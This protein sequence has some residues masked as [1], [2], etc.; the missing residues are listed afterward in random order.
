MEKFMKEIRKSNKLDN[1][2]YDIRGP[3]VEEA[4]RLEREGH[5]IIKLNTGNPSAFGL[6]APDEIIQDVI[7]NLRAAEAYGDSKGLF[8]ARKAI[9]QDCQLKGIRD[10]AIEDIIVGNGVSELIVMIMQGL[11]NNGDEV[12]VPM[13]DYP[14]WTGAANLAGGKAVHYLC[15]ESSNWYPDLADIESKITPNTRAIVMINPNNPTGAVYPKEIVEKMVDIAVKNQLVFLADEIYD[16]VMYDGLKHTPAASLSDD[17]L[18]IT[19]NGLS[20][21]HRLCGFRVGWM[22]ISGKKDDAKDFI[23]GLSILS[24]MRLCSN[25][26]AQ[27][28]IQTAIG[29][30][31]SIFDLT[32]PGGRLCEQRNFSYELFNS[33]PGISCVKPQGGMYLFPKIDI[34]KIPVKDDARFVLD[35]LK[36]KKVMLVQ[37]T[38]F[39][40][41]HPDHFRVVFL[42]PLDEMK[43]V[44]QRF[45]EFVEGYSQE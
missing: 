37:G 1:V 4:A 5:S 11:L 13:P 35:F 25:M 31:Q 10:V 9:M 17:T 16:R 21:S 27:Y 14:L 8:P 20:K 24:S 43:L 7:V 6:Y 28:A 29:G 45:A 3:I 42:P 12:L 22:V 26:P 30:Y 23:E 15:D 41:P 40:W 38:G 34:K 19:L 18:F 36:Q 39:N 32:A 2:F 33:I 44:A